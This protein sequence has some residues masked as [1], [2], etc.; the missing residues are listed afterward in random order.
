MKTKEIIAAGLVIL[1]LLAGCNKTEEPAATNAPESAPS[2]SAESPT[3]PAGEPA[4]ATTEES[5]PPS[6][7]TAPSADSQ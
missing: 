7:T 4:A 2:A 6:T 3:N 5:T 1:A